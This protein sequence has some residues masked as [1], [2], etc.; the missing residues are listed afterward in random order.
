MIPREI[1]DGI[2]ELIKLFWAYFLIIFL[3]IALPTIYIV[4]HNQNEKK[5]PI[6]K[7]DIENLFDSD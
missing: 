5:D 1:V 2:I 3:C 4:L 6:D 7:I